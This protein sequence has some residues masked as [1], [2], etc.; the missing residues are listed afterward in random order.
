MQNQN[1]TIY[2]E[3]ISKLDQDREW[4]LK[5]IDSGKWPKLRSEIASLEREISKFI[6]RARE[7]NSENKKN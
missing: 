1:S 3:L 2:D 5:N 7:K 4:L 6:I